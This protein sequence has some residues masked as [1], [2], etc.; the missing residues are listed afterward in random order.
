MKAIVKNTDMKTQNSK[1]GE[2]GIGLQKWV[3]I[4]SIGETVMYHHNGECLLGV[5]SGKTL[6]KLIVDN[7]IL[8]DR[9]VW[10]VFIIDKKNLQI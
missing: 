9:I 7:K 1:T 10:V 5:V 6:G 2:T 8:V 4:V 3:D